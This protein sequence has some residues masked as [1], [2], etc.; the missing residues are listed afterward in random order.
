MEGVLAELLGWMRSGRRTAIVTLVLV[1]RSAPLGP[2]A[3]MAVSED[4]LVL[5]SVSGGCVESA[6]YEE[7]MKVIASGIPTRVT[8]GIADEQAF[9]I[10]LTCGGTLHLYVEPLADSAGPVLGRLADMLDART[11]VALAT[12]LGGESSP[13]SKVL[14]GESG[15]LEGSYG[16]PALDR[17]IG[18]EARGMLELSESG[19]RSFGTEGERRKDDVAVFIQSFSPP[20]DMY[21][22]GAIDFAAAVTR[23]GKFLGYRVTVCDARE[24]FATALRFPEAD[25]IAV[26]WPHEFLERAPVD[27]RT[28]ICVLTHDPKFDVPLLKA[29]LATSAGYIGAMG[30]RRTDAERTQRLLE[31]GLSPDDLARIA[32]PIGLDIRARSPE[33]VAVSIA[34]ELIA[35]RSGGTCKPLSLITGEIHG[36]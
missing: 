11:P 19:L 14:V 4:G 18:E 28:A 3:V 6:A 36:A 9:G 12:V 30:S 32:G 27:K 10:G 34:A 29:A 2:G 5:G 7:A 8:Y 1:E 20:P 26:E 25:E 16:D 31:E 35:A 24:P 23:I 13:G 22:F 33:E 21:V 15:V 17:V